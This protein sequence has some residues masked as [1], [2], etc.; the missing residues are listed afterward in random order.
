MLSDRCPVC[1]VCDVGVLWPNGWM[2]QDATWFGDRPRSGHIM[3]DEDPAP[4][5]ERVTAAPTFVV[6]VYCGQTARWIKIK[7]SFGTKV[8]LIPGHFVLY[9][10]P[11]PPQK[12]GTAARQFSAHVYCGQTAAWIKMSLGTEVG[13]PRPHCVTWGSSSPPPKEAQQPQLFCSNL[14]LLNGRPSQLLLSSCIS[15]YLRPTVL[16][17][18]CYI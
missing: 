7:M 10:D 4:P 18:C 16:H 2:D 15:V 1:P 6:H 9:G 3:L 11:A 8:G 12:G 13:L 17:V 14:L 5:T